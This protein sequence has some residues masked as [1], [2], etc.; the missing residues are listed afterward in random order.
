MCP[1]E[2]DWSNDE[3]FFFSHLFTFDPN[4]LLIRVKEK[5]CSGDIT[6]PGDQWP[7]LLHKEYKYDPD[8]PWDGL[9]QSALLV[10]VSIQALNR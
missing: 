9:L 1:V 10:S 8:D 5:L 4:I 2:F 6:V 7:I 3:S